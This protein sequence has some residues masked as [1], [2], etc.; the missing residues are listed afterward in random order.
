MNAGL[1]FATICLVP[2]LA[3]AQ[4][5]EAP[6]GMVLIP[7]GEFTMGTSAECASG[8][9]PETTRDASPTH[10]V[11]VDAFWMDA[12]EVTNEQFDKFVKATGYMT[13]AERKPTAEE[14]PG[15]PAEFRIAGSTVFT[16]TPVPVSLGDFRAWW[17]YVAG[18]DWRHPTGPAS[19]LQGRAKFPVV[20]VAWE[21][22][23]AYAKWA[24]KR[25]PT[26]AEWERAARGGL[27]GKP[28][29]WGDVLKPEGKF[30]ANIYQ[31]KFPVAGGDTGEDG[32]KGI[33]P[34][35]QYPPNGY[36][37][38]DM[39]GNVWEWCADWYDPAAYAKRSGGE[40]TCNPQGPAGAV[41]PEE[42][43]RVQRGGSFLCT[44]HYCTR[45]LVGSRGKGEV[46]T[47][48]N[49]LGFRCVVEAKR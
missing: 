35:A 5:S 32:F 27:E 15:V 12:T 19:H 7:A 14:F 34:V 28:Y 17:Q 6:P 31:G 48:S 39:A 37:L 26:E 23:A 36:G 40:L 47:A 24:G 30:V 4:E 11:H 33:A 22:A 16:P 2:A 1:I 42:P 41:H 10:R 13:V 38:F 29:S 43:M 18:A 20:Q 3:I 8:C 49:H 44:D 21:D 46:R 25:L 9:S 45:Y